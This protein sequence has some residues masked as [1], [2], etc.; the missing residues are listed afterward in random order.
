KSAWWRTAGRV[1]GALLTLL[2]YAAT[3][4]FATGFPVFQDPA[5]TGPYSVG[6]TRFFFV[7]SS[8]EDPFAP[9][10][11]TPRELLAAAW[12]PAEVASNA[13]PEPFWPADSAA[14]SAISQ[15]LHTPPS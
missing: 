6:T 15:L 7:D 3:I 1:A 5:T 13:K 4:V 2:L 11:H 9:T 10:P 8:R 14:D 12:Y